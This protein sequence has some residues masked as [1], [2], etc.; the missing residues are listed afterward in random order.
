[1]SAESQ[2]NLSIPMPLLVRDPPLIRNR[3]DY[4]L[5]CDRVEKVENQLIQL[6]MN[7]VE[8]NFNQLNGL[9]MCK[10]RNFTCP[11]PIDDDD[12]GDSEE[13]DDE[14]DDE[15]D[16]DEKLTK[17]I[18]AYENDKKQEKDEKE[19]EPKEEPKPEPKKKG[20]PFKVTSTKSEMIK[21][22]LKNKPGKKPAKVQ[23]VKK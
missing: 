3:L 17:A 4:E 12:D 22:N 21:A 8:D 16:L 6:R 19:E 14:E 7:L 13:V 23:P 9:T 18:Q 1:M 15:D 5:L 10:A 2:S 20:R 11:P